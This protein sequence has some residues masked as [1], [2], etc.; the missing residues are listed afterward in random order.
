LAAA[1][2]LSAC[3]GPPARNEQLEQARIEVHSLEQDPDAQNVASQQ[4][5]D[6]RANLQR[7]SDAFDHRKSTEEVNHFAYLADRQTA[8]GH[9][10]ADELRA[11]RELA[12]ADERRAQIQLQART[13]EAR[14]AREQAQ[15]AQSELAELKAQ[16]AQQRGTELTLASDVLF[17]TGAAELKPGANLQISRLAN[18]MRSNPKTRIMVEGHTDSTGSAAFNEQLSEQRAQAVASTLEMQGIATDR[19]QTV[20][21]GEDFPVATNATADGR[22]QNRRVDIVLS[23]ASGNFAQG[24]KEGPVAR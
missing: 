23:D 24:V 1:G 11:R 10:L 6:A 3:A 19:I 20:G 7:A 5:S 2:I 13:E 14:R 12:N 22:Q 4:L 8:T 18:Y 15:R 21:R 17:N 16:Q 9:A